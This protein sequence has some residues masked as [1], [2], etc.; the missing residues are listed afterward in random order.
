VARHHQVTSVPPHLAPGRAGMRTFD[1]D[2]VVAG[3]SFA[4]LAAARALRGHDV[5]VLDPHPVGSFETSAGG[6]PLATLEALDAAATASEL[7]PHVVVHT[8]RGERVVPLP[9]PYAVIDYEVF[10]RRLANQ[11]DAPVLRRRATGYQSGAVLTD[12]GPITCR[13]A[14]DASGHRAVLASSLRPGYTRRGEMGAA[15][16]VVRRRPRGFP[17]G[18]HFYLGGDWPP[19]YGWAFGAGD[20][21]RAGVGLL[22]ATRHAGRLEEALLALLRVARLGSGD[23]A[24]ARHGGLIPLR[25]RAAVVDDVFVVGDAAGQVLPGTAEGIRPALHFATRLGELLA[26]ALDGRCRL[27]DARLAY[28]GQVAAKAGGYRALAITQRVLTAL[29]PAA[30]ADTVTTISPWRLTA[31][32][33]DRYVRAFSIPSARTNPSTGSSISPPSSALRAYNRRAG[34]TRHA[35]LEEDHSTAARERSRHP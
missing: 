20:T 25:R 6:V 1:A 14:I 17:V 28:Q 10:C 34:P 12:Q 18:L 27:G 9:S 21:V 22:Y 2:I 13:A 23:E 26:D 19:G 31:A 30:A 32:L 5:V 11:A 4:G 29:P 15:V 3:A 16:E 7:H 35:T 33:V 24:L 8:P